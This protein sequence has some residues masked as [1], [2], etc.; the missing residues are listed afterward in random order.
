M[1]RGLGPWGW[2]LLVL[3]AGSLANGLWMLADPEIY[4]ELHLET[5]NLI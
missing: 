4:L 3:G 1:T 5:H 2:L